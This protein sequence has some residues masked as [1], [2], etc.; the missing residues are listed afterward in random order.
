[1]PFINRV[2]IK[3][4]SVEPRTVFN[5]ASVIN[6]GITRHLEYIMPLITVPF[7]SDVCC[8][9]ILEV[10]RYLIVG[11]DSQQLFGIVGGTL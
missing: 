1:M 5:I 9:I 7:P 4:V 6:S 3:F 10:N 8:I 11:Y 2:F